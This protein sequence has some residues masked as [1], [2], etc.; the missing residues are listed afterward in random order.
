MI[1]GR[2]V[3]RSQGRFDRARIWGPRAC[4]RAAVQPSQQGE[5]RRVGPNVFTL[6]H[7]GGGNL[8]LRR[9]RADP[10]V[11]AN[12]VRVADRQHA[13]SRRMNGDLHPWRHPCRHGCACSSQTADRD[14]VGWERLLLFSGGAPGK[15][16][17]RSTSAGL[18]MGVTWP[19]S[20]N[21]R[22]AS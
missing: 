10:W 15:R 2:S 5:V 16:P 18:W 20:S 9:R 17:T 22:L 21:R 7:S 12:E 11:R 14:V 19:V 4:A 8:Q 1:T 3:P 13:V 6:D